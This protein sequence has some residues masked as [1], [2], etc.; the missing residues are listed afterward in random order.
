MSTLKYSLPSRLL[1]FVNSLAAT[2]FIGLAR[3]VISIGSTECVP[4]GPPERP[5]NFLVSGD[6]EYSSRIKE[7]SVN[8]KFR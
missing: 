3:L 8:I 6:S 7:I 2:L 5:S 4:H 1:F